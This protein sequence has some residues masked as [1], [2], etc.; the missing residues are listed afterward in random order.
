AFLESPAPLAG[1]NRQDH[2]A[3]VVAE[4]RPALA[5]L[6]DLD[7]ELELSAGLFHLLAILGTGVGGFLLRFGLRLLEL[8]AELLERLYAVLAPTHV[9]VVDAPFVEVD[10]LAG[11]VV[12]RRLARA[13]DG[14]G[15]LD[16][17]AR[18]TAAEE[19]DDAAQ[20]PFERERRL[21]PGLHV[22]L[23]RRRD[24]SRDKNRKCRADDLLHDCSSGRPP[25]TARAPLTPY[26][27]PMRRE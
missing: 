18:I 23:Q 16:A 17:L 2:L 21:F 25:G 12:R 6:G 11:L 4:H 20:E 27:T 5:G 3:R 1:R 8:G 15:R 7:V 22:G 9:E 10:D 13:L 19:P 24:E 26:H 14:D